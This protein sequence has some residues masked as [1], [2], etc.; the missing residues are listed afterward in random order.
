MAEVYNGWIMDLIKVKKVN[1]TYNKIIAEPSL[2][3]ELSDFFT[4]DVPGAKFMPEY[5]NKVWDGK[6]RLLNTMTCQ[7][8]AGLNGYIESFCESRG[9]NLEYLENVD[10]DE[11]TYEDAESFI[12]TLNIPP[13]FEKRDYQIEAFS[14]AIRKRRS[15]LLSPTASG[16][17]FI[18]YL[19]MRYYATKTLIIVPTTALVSQLATD[20]ID[21]GFNSDR[22]VHRI[23]SGQDKITD[24]PITISTW[25]SIYKL[26]KEYF[27]SFD[28]V[29]GDEAHLFKAKS[30]ISIMRKLSNCK[31]RFGF[32]G[33][34]DKTQ[35]NKLVLEGLFGQTKKVTTTHELMQ[36]KIVA[37]LSIK[38]LVLNYPNH[39]K[40]LIK[41]L[42][43]QSEMDFLCRLPERNKYLINLA[44]S[45]EGNT[46]MLFQ[47][48]EKHGKILYDMIKTIAP[49]RKVYYV[50]GKVDGDE[51]ETIRKIVDKETNSIIIASYGTF[52]TGTNIKNLNNIIF[53][54]PYKSVVKVLQSIGRGLRKSSTKTKATLYDIADDLSHGQR[55][56]ITL[57]HFMERISIY[58]SEIF[59]Y[60]IFKVSINI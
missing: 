23:F 32:T 11:F 49:D 20:F 37:D 44:L 30:L 7:L 51:R 12:N 16:K 21:Y 28:L 50:D 25:Q 5:K 58:N 6:I 9:Y 8:Y 33:T 18:I 40:K 19:I 59:K 53:A 36:K 35:T 2:I 1:E 24:K 14:H 47:Y 3:M 41:T 22:Y 55:N 52:S 38:C 4:F 29:I 13:A 56:N 57:S 60:K 48:T 26:P 45:I 17:S 10:D 42:D 27:D 43:Y 15:I 46:M 54:S 39:I 31:Y 34:L